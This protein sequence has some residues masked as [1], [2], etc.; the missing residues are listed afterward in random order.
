MLLSGLFGTP[1][2]VGFL[3]GGIIFSLFVDIDFIFFFKSRRA[4]KHAH[5]HRSLHYPLLYIPIGVLIFYPFGWQWALLFALCSIAH[6]IH[7]SIGIGWGIKWLYPFSK[8]HFAFLYQYS[9]KGKPRLPTK[10]FYSWKPEEV[11]SLAE[12]YGDDDWVKN[13]YRRWHPY[14]IIEFATLLLAILVLCFYYLRWSMSSK[15]LAG[16]NEKQQEA[17]QTTE[18]PLLV[19][20]AAG[21]GKTRVLAHRVAY[22]MEQG[23]APESILAITFTNKAGGEMRER[24][25]KLIRNSTRL[26][27]EQELEI[28][29]YS[30]TPLMGTFH[31]ICARFLRR[32]LANLGQSINSNFAIYDTDDQLSLVKKVMEELEL[33]S[34]KFNPRAILSHISQAKNEL[35][36]P[37]QYADQAKEFFD[38]ITAQ[39]YLRYQAGLSNSNALDFD[40]LLFMMVRLLRDNSAILA[41][42]Q[43]QFQYILVDE[44]QDTNRAQYLFLKLLA[45]SHRNIMAVGD[46]YQSIYAFRQAD[47]RNILSFE[48]DYPEAKIIFLEQNYRSTQTI[49]AAAQQVILNNQFQRHKKLWTENHTGEKISVQNLGNEKREGEWLAKTI[50][51]NLTEGQKLSDHCVLYRTHAQSRALEEAMLKYGLPYRIVGGLKF[52]ERKEIKDILAYLRLVNNPRDAISLERIYNTPGRNIGVASFKK[53]MGEADPIRV[54][55]RAERGLKDLGRG[56]SNGVG[57]DLIAFLHDQATKTDG[58]LKSKALAGVKELAKTLTDLTSPDKAKLTLFRF[59]KHLLSELS[60]QDYLKEKTTEAEARWENVQ[61]LLTVAKKYDDLNLAEGLAKFLEEV[62]LIQDADRT[63]ETQNLIT[64][65]TIHAAKGLE[66]PTVFMVGME[67]GVFPHSRSLINPAELEEERR[68]CYVGITRAKKKLYLTHCSYRTMYGNTQ[69]NPVSRFLGEIPEDLISQTIAEEIVDTD[70]PDWYEK[71][72]KYD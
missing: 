2:S 60:Y 72:I 46:D 34:K 44:Y 20:A 51:A 24:I 12:K 65:M 48:K 10:L 15:L 63:T 28:R 40:D 58:V 32:E 59:I 70:Y 35:L 64:L 53:L 68:L 43:E 5:E 8:N 4:G 61:E 50:K 6:F 71:K 11:K 56:D 14:A 7:D 45:Q 67:E 33:D 47:I 21:S 52:Y 26:P 16:L 22:L 18:G 55:A 41:K 62:A 27:D 66:F 54:H 19:I 29:N 39:V 17:V 69:Y 13:I 37:E 25:E 9:P 38:K 30:G 42:Y 3:L 23:V 49:L 36:E 1:L 31:S 57:M